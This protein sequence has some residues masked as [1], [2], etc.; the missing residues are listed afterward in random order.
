MISVSII[1]PVY[2]EEKTIIKQLGLINQKKVQL[3]DYVF[4]VIIVDD[5]SNDKTEILLKENKE[6]YD[7]Y[8]RNE[9]NFGK[10]YSV[11][12][13][14]NNSNNDIILIQDADL[15]YL[16]ENYD[17]LLKPFKD[18]DA[19][20][21]YGSRFKTTEIN[22]VL[23]FFH[24]IA[25]KIITFS[26]NIFSDLNLTDVEVG[27]KLFKRKLFEKINIKE[28]SFGFEIEVTHKISNLRK[29][30]KIF[31][32]GISYFGRSYAEGKK[33]GIKDAFWAFFCILKY[34]LFKIK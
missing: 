9:K 14:I 23:F 21:V 2:N 27:Y 31:E 12:V 4:E 13:G 18:Y 28:N 22:R 20:V 10:G 24:S 1:I 19:D 11:N 26:S 32:V 17:N 3:K 7:K 16:P 15:E 25:N 34:G 8:Y 6:L 5:Y 29:D 33:I 30:L